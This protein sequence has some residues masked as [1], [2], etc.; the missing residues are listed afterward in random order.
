[1]NEHV[2]RPHVEVTTTGVE[3]GT[4]VPP[5]GRRSMLTDFVADF[6][7]ALV[8][9]DRRRPVWVSTTTGR[10]YAPGIG[11]HTETRTVELVMAELAATKPEYDGVQLSVPYPSS[12]RQ[13]CD[14]V[15][16]QP[17]PLAVEVKMLRFL[18]DNGRPNDNILMHILSPYPAHRSALTDV[19]KLAASGFGV[20]LAILIYGYDYPDWPMDPAIEAFETLAA[21]KG[22]IG[23]RV[24]ATFEG[25]VHPVHQRGRVFAWEVRPAS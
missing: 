16:P 2:P 11:P 12:P 22:E 17:R 10:A 18:G 14:V 19:A 5:T 25:L 7:N 1:M 24:T 20:P 9:V 15:L 3:K 4:A 21:S 8:A 23:T 6:A 13:R